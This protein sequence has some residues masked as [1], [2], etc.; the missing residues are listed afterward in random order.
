MLSKILDLFYP[1]LCFACEEVPLMKGTSICTSCEYKI[2]P[3]EYHLREE[4]PVSERFWGRVKLERATSAFSFMKGG[5]LQ[6]LIHK[7]KYENKPQIGVELGRMYAAM[8]L[9]DD[10]WKSV[11][12]IIP[13]PLHP[14]KRHERGY[15][16]AELWAMGLSEGL[17]VDWTDQF[18]VRRDYTETQTKKSRMER[19]QNVENAFEVPDGTKIEGK[20]LLIV[21]DV[22]TTGATLEACALTLLKVP[23]VSISIACIALAG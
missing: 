4:N 10:F 17:G 8:L 2:R 1:Q 14:K 22:L 6:N 11:D 15:N 12:Y 16:Q 3:T 21:D 13:V 18:L 7:L 19:F 5:L 20:H 23:N 9:E